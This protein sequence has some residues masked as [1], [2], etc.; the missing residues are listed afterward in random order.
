MILLS[1][2][3]SAKKSLIFPEFPETLPAANY[4]HA[5]KSR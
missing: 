1:D 5:M 3:T 4:S 2:E